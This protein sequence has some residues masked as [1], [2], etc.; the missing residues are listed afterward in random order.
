MITMLRYIDVKK[1]GE[2]INK[3]RCNK[4]I[5]IKELAYYLGDI[6]KQA[7]Y[8]WESGFS[9]PSIE[10]LARMSEIFELSMDDIVVKCSNK[11]GE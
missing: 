8:R 11:E 4:N 2:R 10:N 9:L 1:T 3:L 6:S 5:S 7:I